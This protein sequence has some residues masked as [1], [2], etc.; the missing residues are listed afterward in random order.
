MKGRLKLRNADFAAK[1]IHIANAQ[2][3]A[4]H[5]RDVAK[6]ITL[7]SYA[8]HAMSILFAQMTWKET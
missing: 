1:T 6:E 4:K 5:A 7:Q 2:P 8:E 3:M